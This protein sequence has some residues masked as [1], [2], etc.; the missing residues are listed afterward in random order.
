MDGEMTALSGVAA[1]VFS[2]QS[3]VEM[4]GKQPSPLACCS[5]NVPQA[6]ESAGWRRATWL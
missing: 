6:R 4:K 2:L 3:D 5:Y 1:R